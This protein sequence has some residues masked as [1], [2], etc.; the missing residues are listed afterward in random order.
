MGMKCDFMAYMDHLAFDWS[1]GKVSIS[2]GGEEKS[3]SAKMTL[4]WLESKF[5]H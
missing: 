5:D 4:P 1:T 3:N 2:F